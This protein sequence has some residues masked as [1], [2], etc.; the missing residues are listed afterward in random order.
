MKEL[1]F[2]FFYGSEDNYMWEFLD[3]IAEEMEKT[4]LFT[5]EMSSDQCRDVARDFL[6]RRKLW[7]RD[8]L[9][10]YQ[11][12]EGKE[13]SASDS[14]IRTPALADCTD[15]RLIFES[16]PRL[17]A[18]AFTSEK[19]AEWTFNKLGDRALDQFKKT[20][21][22]WKKIAKNLPLDE[23]ISQK[24]QKPVLQQ[25]IG[26]HEIDFYIL[27]SPTGRSQ[28]KGLGIK[29]KQKIYKYVLFTTGTTQ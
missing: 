11:R 10:Q 4:K 16:H 12:K 25:L 23:Y 9:Q 20:F 6:Q 22:A 24:Y 13:A 8:I 5:K 15:F 29:E 27:P 3:N 1:D 17:K 2:D 14:D 19:A 7:M 28:M 26:P 18:V 21:S